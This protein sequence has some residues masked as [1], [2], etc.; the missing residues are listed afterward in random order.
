MATTICPS[1]GSKDLEKVA[2]KK[3]YP[4]VYGKPAEWDEEMHHCLTCGESGNFS[5]DN[6]SIAENAIELAKKQSVNTMLDSLVEGGIKMAYLERAF[7]LSP[8]TT[9]RWKA[10]GCSASSIA[11]IR[12]I[13]TFPWMVEVADAHFDPRFAAKRLLQAAGQVVYNAAS[14]ANLG[15]A[16]A[17]MAIVV[18]TGRVDISACL[19][20]DQPVSPN[21]FMIP[22]MHNLTKSG[23]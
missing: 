11:L 10:G 15:L 17:S 1:C 3:S 14:E 2:N 23:D 18:N 7:E 6:D 12:I 20:F 22:L 5:D 16:S 21:N 9:S 4:I 8:R 13:R 19:E